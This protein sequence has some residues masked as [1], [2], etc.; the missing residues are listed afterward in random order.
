MFLSL[1]TGGRG[2]T[3]SLIGLN[4]YEISLFFGAWRR[5]L[6]ERE[7]L[8]QWA[9]RRLGGGLPFLLSRSILTVV[10]FLYR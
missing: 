7:S 9:V 8:G 4:R 3:M 2:R 10:G 6:A 1:I 5:Q